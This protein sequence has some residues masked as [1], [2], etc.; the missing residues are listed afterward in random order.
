[1]GGSVRRARENMAAGTMPKVPPPMAPRTMDFEAP[2]A[3]PRPRGKP[4]PQSNTAG[5]VKNGPLPIGVAISRPTQVPQWPLSGTIEG[6]SPEPYEPPPNRGPPPPRPPRPSHVP[7]LLDASKLQDHTPVFPYQPTQ[8]TT[9]VDQGQSRMRYQD[10]EYA[11]SSPSTDAQSSS[12][13]STVSSVGSIPDFPVPAIPVPVP[14]RRSANLGP[15]PSSRRGAS[16]YYSQASYV[17]PIPE[18]SESPRTSRTIPSNHSHGSYASS[19]AI[20]S[21]W[22]TQSPGYHSDADSDD[23]STDEID[24]VDED[25]DD[26]SPMEV[27]FG[28]GMDVVPEGHESRSSLSTDGNNDESGLIRSASFGKRG[29]PSL[30]ST[31]TANQANLERPDVFPLQRTASEF[32]IGAAVTVDRVEDPFRSGTGLIDGSI[33]SSDL[34]APQIGRA[35]TVDEATLSPP[36]RAQYNTFQAASALHQDQSRTKSPIEFFNRLSAIR[37]PP[38]LDM[39]A[40]RDAEARGSLTS[41]PDLIRRATRLAAMMDRGTRPGS[42]LSVADWPTE[43]GPTQGR[44]SSLIC[45]RA[46]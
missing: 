25:S 42:V 7:S 14:A 13:P 35:V 21:S 10:D 4:Q 9:L 2:R 28:Y 3:V 6:G 32:P 19:A 24:D 37:Q 23:V 43:K 40:V 26:Y 45:K 11:L 20:P 15:P 33:S 18:V 27:N 46:L 36:A 44:F 8:S 34:S 29:K 31:R 5:P 30:I 38:R 22:G 41:L 39:N 12:R 1:M 16:S 17:S